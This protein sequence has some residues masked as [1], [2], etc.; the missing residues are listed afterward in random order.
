MHTYIRAY[1]AIT[2]L[3]RIREVQTSNLGWGTKQKVKVKLSLWHFKLRTTPWRRI[4]GVEVWSTH[5]STSTQDGGEWSVSCPSCFTPRERAPGTNWIGGWVGPRAILDA[6]VKR[7]ISSPRWESKRRTP[8]VQPRL[9]HQ[10]LWIRLFF[11]ILIS[12][13]PMPHWYFEIGYDYFL[14]H[15]LDS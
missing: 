7:R 5:S 11:V 12:S 2:W 3:T 14:S 4:G 13:M 9:G 10:L 1:S 6:L 15:P 8:I